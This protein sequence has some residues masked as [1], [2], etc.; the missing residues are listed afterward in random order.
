MNNYIKHFL[1]LLILVILIFTGCADEPIEK[2]SINFES[3]QLTLIENDSLKLS[4]KWLSAKNSQTDYSFES[5]SP[6]VALVK[7]GYVKGLKVGTAKIVIYLKSISST[8]DTCIVTVVANKALELGTLERPYLIYDIIDLELMCTRINTENAKYGDKY[9]KLMNDIVYSNTAKD[10]LAIGTD[11]INSF[12]GVFDGNFKTITGLNVNNTSIIQYM[13]LFGYVSGSTIKNLGVTWSNL[14]TE[15]KNVGGICGFCVNSTIQNC[16]SRSRGIT[17]HTNHDFAAEWPAFASGGGITGSSINSTINNCH[18][19]ADIWAE[20]SGGIAGYASGG[21]ICN[22]FSIGSITAWNSKSYAGGITG[23]GGII[24]NC[25]STGEISSHSTNLE[26]FAGGISSKCQKIDNCYS[27]SKISASNRSLYNYG[28]KVYAGGISSII[29]SG[30]TIINCIALNPSIISDSRLNTSYTIA[31]RITYRL[32]STALLLSN[33]AISTQIV[34]LISNTTQQVYTNLAN[35]PNKDGLDLVDQPITL[36]N[37]NVSSKQAI[38]GIQ[39]REW[40]CRTYEN[41]GNPVFK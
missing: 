8:A 31:T 18:T 30:D 10:W 38:N 19:N 15:C 7:D 3:K 23:L 21:V 5:L 36:L 33:N 17:G 24:I 34:A 37:K 9:F 12:R 25:F 20:L 40:V 6:N 39:L 41:S 22:C 16:S 26:A 14:H 29:E 2:P 35:T 28:Y 1:P 27:S 4:A 13:G 32:S 11:E